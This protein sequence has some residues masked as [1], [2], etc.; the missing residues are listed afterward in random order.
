[1]SPLRKQGS[2]AKKLD[3]CF[4]RN[5]KYCFRNRNYLAAISKTSFRAQRGI[6]QFE[7]ILHPAQGNSFEIVSKPPSIAAQIIAAHISPPI[8]QRQ[9]QTSF[10][11]TPA[12]GRF[13]IKFFVITGLFHYP[14]YWVSFLPGQLRIFNRGLTNI[15]FFGHWFKHSDQKTL[16]GWKIP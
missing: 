9:V 4:R 12:L 16:R 14:Y 13:L 15:D 1:M 8:R 2:T 11:F 10:L 7:S 6:C 5:D 3:S